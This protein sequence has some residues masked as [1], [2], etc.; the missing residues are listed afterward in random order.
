MI[1]VN[2][3]NEGRIPW[4]NVEGPVFGYPLSDGAFQL[5]SKDSR[6][7]VEITTPYDA[8]IARTRYLNR[9]GQNIVEE[10]VKVET[11]EEKPQPRKLEI[12]IDE[13]VKMPLTISI[14]DGSKKTEE[15]VHPEINSKVELDADDAEID[16]AL[17]GLSEK[18][19]LFTPIEVPK[20]E[21]RKY[22][23]KTLETMTKREMKQILKDRG[24]FE[25]PNAGKYRD[26]VSDLVE[27]VLRTQQ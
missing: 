7:I 23:R 6:M 3:L 4:I 17:E 27:K 24:Y 16:K 2:I 13:S 21:I 18:E 15:V 11:V 10:E 26:T 14:D 9:T 20:Q 5:I 25:G 12:N 19:Q 22:S 8:E 1:L